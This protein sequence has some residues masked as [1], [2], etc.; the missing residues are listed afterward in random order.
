MFLIL[1]NVEVSSLLPCFLNGRRPFSF[2]RDPPSVSITLHRH[3][4]VSRRSFF[5]HT[6]VEPLHGW[7]IAC[8]SCTRWGKLGRTCFGDTKRLTVF[9]GPCS[10]WRPPRWFLPI[11][12]RSGGASRLGL[13]VSVFSSLLEIEPCVHWLQFPCRCRLTSRPRPRAPRGFLICYCAMWRR[14][15]R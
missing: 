10:S 4:V 7:G 12:S 11:E 8:I 15:W 9:T 13:K 3:L 1:S 6:H 14:D 5:G 2:H